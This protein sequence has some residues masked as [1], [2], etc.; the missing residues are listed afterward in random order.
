VA[1]VAAAASLIT[2]P[3]IGAADTPDVQA[4]PIP[5]PTSAAIKIVRIRFSSPLIF[6]KDWLPQTGALPNYVRKRRV[7]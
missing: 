3:L 1:P 4:K 2:V 6:S 5:A 7:T